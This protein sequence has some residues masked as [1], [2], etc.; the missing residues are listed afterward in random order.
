[1]LNHMSHPGA[2]LSHFFKKNLFIYLFIYERHREAE[3][4]AEGEVGS[5][6][7]RESN[8]ELNLRTL[9]S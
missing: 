9:G 8:V 4:Y 7:S 3:T 5:S 2:P 6:L 1:M